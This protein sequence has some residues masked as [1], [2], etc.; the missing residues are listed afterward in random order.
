MYDTVYFVL[1]LK[2]FSGLSCVRILFCKYETE[3]LFRK[4]IKQEE[5]I[6]TEDVMLDD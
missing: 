1:N 6:K 4:F 3:F 2:G 5:K